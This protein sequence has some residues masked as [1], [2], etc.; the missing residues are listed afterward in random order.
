MHTRDAI[1]PFGKIAPN[2]SILVSKRI[3]KKERLA[4]IAGDSVRPEMSK[5]NAR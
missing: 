2:P 5:P 4:E 3:D 1:F